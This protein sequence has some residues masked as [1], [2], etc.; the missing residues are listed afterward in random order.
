M[1]YRLDNCRQPNSQ[2]LGMPMSGTANQNA[3]DTKVKVMHAPV[4][5]TQV[6]KGLLHELAHEHHELVE[7]QAVDAEPLS[8]HGGKEH[9]KVPK[10]NLRI[11]RPLRAPPAAQMRHL[12]ALL[13]H[14]ITVITSSESCG[15]ISASRWAS[16]SCT[17]DTQVSRH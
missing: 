5:V 12:C 1:A 6:H 14:P 9:P 10:G 3:A 16:A 11:A 4:G 7:P 13:S 8:P 15:R 17:A 2:L